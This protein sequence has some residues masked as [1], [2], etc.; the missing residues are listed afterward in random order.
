MRR[1]PLAHAQSRDREDEFRREVRHA[2]DEA[3]G[4][5]AARRG[6]H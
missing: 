1:W 3:L 5:F 6:A 2:L 4:A